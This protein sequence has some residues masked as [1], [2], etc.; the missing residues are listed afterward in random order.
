MKYLVALCILCASTY[1]IGNV[2]AQLSPELMMEQME[3]EGM[4]NCELVVLEERMYVPVRIEL[5]HEPVT[6]Q[7]IETSSQ[8]PQ[9]ELF[10]EKSESRLGLITNS[11]DYFTIKILL[12]YASR[13]DVPRDVGYSFQSENYIVERG[14][15]KHEGY[16]FCKVF[17]VNTSVAPHIPTASEILDIAGEITKEKFDRV[18]ISINE[19]TDLIYLFV[20]TSLIFSGLI[21]IM[22][23]LLLVARYRDTKK[24][25]ILKAEQAREYKSAKSELDKAV[26]MTNVLLEQSRVI[27]K[28]FQVNIDELADKLGKDIT[29][30]RESIHADISTILHVRTQIEKQEPESITT[31]V[32][33]TVKQNIPMPKT[34]HIDVDEMIK[35]KTYDEIKEMHNDLV[36][37]YES[38]NDHTKKDEIYNIVMKLEDIL[39][40][41]KDKK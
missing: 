26:A 27:N 2:T 23:M 11:T 36:D 17:Q 16:E 19:N 6:N 4:G 8:D 40:E 41:R 38:T 31:K 29:R 10:F 15:W 18:T 22:M 7:I 25:N 24:A 3:R 32:F 30:F 33:K 14:T 35:G 28:K 37:R 39:K 34:K 12:D 20:M 1:A 9:S 13:E 5:F 21:I